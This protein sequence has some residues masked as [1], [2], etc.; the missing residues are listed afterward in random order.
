LSKVCVPPL[1]RVTR[2]VKVE[3]DVEAGIVAAKL[4]NYG[5]Y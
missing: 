1:V 5:T 4:K 3:M 2:T